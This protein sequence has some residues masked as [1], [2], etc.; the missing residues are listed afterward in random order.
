MENQKKIMLMG[1]LLIILVVLGIY[2]LYERK[3]FNFN[4]TNTK[5]NQIVKNKDNGEE[6]WDKVEDLYEKKVFNKHVKVKNLNLDKEK[7][8]ITYE[9]ENESEEDIILN[10]KVVLTYGDGTDFNTIDL[11]GN[12]SEIVLK[13][14][15]SKKFKIEKEEII[16]F[17]KIYKSE[18]KKNA[19][20]NDVK[21]YKFTYK[22]K[23]LNQEKDVINIKE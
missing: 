22:D 13:N 12:D 21:I 2:I 1:I 11:I 4:V 10:N 14:R 18:V 7:D 19:V 15:E 16:K 6:N 3:I 5:S 8:T 17:R 20:L 9:I 23:K